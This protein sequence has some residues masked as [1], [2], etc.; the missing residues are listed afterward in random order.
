MR[1][2]T[3]I[4]V[5]ALAFDTEQKKLRNAGGNVGGPITVSPKAIS[6]PARAS[7][8]KSRL[9]SRLD[10]KRLDNIAYLRCRG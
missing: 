2:V 3:A 5:S 1:N 8:A 4:A 10:Y 9:G 7:Y 6:V